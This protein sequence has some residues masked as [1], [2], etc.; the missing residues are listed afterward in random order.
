M[1][2]RY[3]ICRQFGAEV[4]LLNPAA[5]GVAWVNYTKELAS[6]P[7]HWYLPLVAYAST[8]HLL[9]TTHRLPLNPYHVLLTTLSLLPTTYHLLLTPYLPPLANYTLPYYSRCTGTSARWRTR[10]TLPRTSITPAPRSGRSRPARRTTNPHNNPNPNP[11]LNPNPNPDP[12]PKPRPNPNPRPHPHP[13]PNQVDY[14]VHGIGTG[15]CIAGVGKFLKEKNPA[16]KAL[17]S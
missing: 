15:G 6:Q 10:A 2:E 7:D 11:N 3:I 16:C 8:C 9:L 4:R 5:G 12:S 17:P 14:F 1:F 13:H